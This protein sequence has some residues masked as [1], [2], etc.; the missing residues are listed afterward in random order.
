MEIMRVPHALEVFRFDEIAFIPAEYESREGEIGD[1]A[2]ELLD[3]VLLQKGSLKKLTHSGRSWKGQLRATTTAKTDGPSL[4]AF[5]VLEILELE[6]HST[7]HLWHYARAWDLPPK[8]KTLRFLGALV[9]HDFNARDWDTIYA[10]R[11]LRGGMVLELVIKNMHPTSARWEP[12]RDGMLGELMRGL[13]I[14]TKRKDVRLVLYGLN[15]FKGPPPFLYGDEAL[16]E[17]LVPVPDIRQI[18]TARVSDL[19]ELG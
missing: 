2:S 15:S 3:A 10:L 13:I 1:L 8:L 6:C 11:C 9:N 19:E 5:E 18:D 16:E 7:L 14:E 17:I 4:S 12:W